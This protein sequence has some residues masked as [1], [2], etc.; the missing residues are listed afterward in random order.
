MLIKSSTKC[1]CSCYHCNCLD[2]AVHGAVT[3]FNR[4]RMGRIQQ[5]EKHT[6]APRYWG[7]K[8]LGRWSTEGREVRCAAAGAMIRA[9]V[10][11]ALQRELGVWSFIL[12]R[13]KRH[14]KNISTGWHLI[15]KNTIME[16]FK[17]IKKIS[18]CAHQLLLSASR[19]VMFHL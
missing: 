6:D 1:K 15:F 17:H 9:R 7:T 13:M 10:F 14:W 16:N 18:L 4:R 2:W 12:R 11:K 8:S 5:K 19:S 3:F